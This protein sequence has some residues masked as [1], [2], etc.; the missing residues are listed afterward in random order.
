MTDDR[1]SRP[2]A[3]EDTRFFR[4]LS[5]ERHVHFTNRFGAAQAPATIKVCFRLRRFSRRARL[6]FSKIPSTPRKLH[7]GVPGMRYPT[8]TVDPVIAVDGYEKAYHNSDDSNHILPVRAHR[9]L[10]SSAGSRRAKV[11]CAILLLRREVPATHVRR[12]GPSRRIPRLPCGTY[13]PARILDQRPLGRIVGLSDEWFIDTGV[14]KHGPGS[15]GLYSAANRPAAEP[16]IP[17][18]HG[19]R[20]CLQ[21]RVE[22]R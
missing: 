6:V 7:I 13:T 1:I 18:A 5:I 17:G 4:G 2:L 8:R 16:F 11:W 19:R 15:N 20:G 9:H 10:S 12:P 21:M 3:P 22:W 14:Q